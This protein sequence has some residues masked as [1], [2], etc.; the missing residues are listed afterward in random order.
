MG[1]LGGLILGVL[2]A[3]LLLIVGAL[4]M[5]L[6]ADTPVAPPR[7]VAAPDLRL[8]V[9]ESFLN[10]YTEPPPDGTILIDVL[11]GNQIRLVADITI[12]A[13]G[14]SVPVQLTG[15]IQ[16]QP[17]GQSLQ[18]VLRDTQVSGLSLPV[19]LTNLFSED[20]VIINQNLDQILAEVSATLGVPV[21]VTNLSTTDTHLQIEI[22]EVP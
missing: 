1:C 22:Q 14:V 2:G 4:A 11:P 16:L 10:R 20:I 17:S 5:A 3:G 15:L 13:L 12:Q 21:M 19:E 8:T 7:P 6:T 9:D 18:A